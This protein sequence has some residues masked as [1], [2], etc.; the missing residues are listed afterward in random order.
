[1]SRNG[2]QT[3]K[4]WS[5]LSSTRKFK[6]MCIQN[7]VP[8]EAA[9]CSD[10]PK[11]IKKISD[12]SVNHLGVV[13]DW[14]TCSSFVV[15]GLTILHMNMN[16]LR[17]ILR[18]IMVTSLHIYK[19][20]RNK[21]SL[22][23]FYFPEHEFEPAIDTLYSE[24]FMLKHLQICLKQPYRYIE[25]SNHL[26]LTQHGNTTRYQYS[27]IL[28]F[29]DCDKCGFRPFHK[30]PTEK[31]IRLL[32]LSWLQIIRPWNI[33][34]KEDYN[35]FIEKYLLQSKAYQIY[36]EHFK[37]LYIHLWGA[38]R[39]TRYFLSLSDSGPF[40]LLLSYRLKTTAAAICGEH[41]VEALNNS[42]EL[43]I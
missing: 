23:L 13:N 26:I 29:I 17:V 14:N 16:G 18:T 41:V 2:S 15:F 36:L 9:G 24:S 43:L 4:V 34:I 1:M 39:Y 25:A 6:K 37:S 20:C 19:L 10:N 12:Y 38:T 30:S 22:I 40:Y 5:D 21:R 31:L 11:V 27:N 8:M 35:L 42:V 28:R 7:N 3:H 33:C 32:L